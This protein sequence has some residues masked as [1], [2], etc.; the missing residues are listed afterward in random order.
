MSHPDEQNT[1]TSSTTSASTAAHAPSQPDPEILTIENFEAAKRAYAKSGNWDKVCQME[2]T[3]LVQQQTTTFD[4]HW[5]SASQANRARWVE[6]RHGD[7]TTVLV[8]AGKVLS[9]KHDVQSDLVSYC[10]IMMIG[11]GIIFV[12]GSLAEVTAKLSIETPSMASRKVQDYLAKMTAS[13]TDLDYALDQVGAAISRKLDDL[14][15]EKEG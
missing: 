8:E 2:M 14:E 4:Q 15:K 1:T 11:G 5:K 3:V 10:Q 9:I 12:D 6:F 7:N 13:M